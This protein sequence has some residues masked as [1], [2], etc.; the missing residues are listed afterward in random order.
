[1]NTNDRAIAG[2]SIPDYGERGL[3]TA[4]ASL[5]ACWWTRDELGVRSWVDNVGQ[6]LW[7]P[8][9]WDD[10][11]DGDAMRVNR[12]RI[13]R[14]AAMALPFANGVDETAWRSLL[15]ELSGLLATTDDSQPEA[16][17]DATIA[18]RM[19]D[20]A[21]ALREKD[22]AR[23]HTTRP[24]HYARRCDADG[25]NILN[26][27]NITET[28]A[29]WEL[30]EHTTGCSRTQILL[31]VQALDTDP[32]NTADNPLIRPS[33]RGERDCLCHQSSS[34]SKPSSMGL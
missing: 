18:N 9:A 12:A 3:P 33:T 2:W 29:R 8:G 5:L 4:L 31:D 19:A 32:R 14:V 10:R 13:I 16:E 23:M 34:G 6:R 24:D 22:Y 28:E 27:L 25:D 17:Y 26:S 30:A 21:E 1:M 20:L 7:L 11:L 15:D